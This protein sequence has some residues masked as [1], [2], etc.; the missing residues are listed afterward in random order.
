MRR[1]A[2]SWLLL[3]FLLLGSGVLG[4]V[5]NLAHALE[6]AIEDASHRDDGSPIQHEQHEHDETNCPVHAQLHMPAI[7][8]AWTPLLVL[9]GIWIPFLTQG[10]AVV[11]LRLHSPCFDSRGPPLLER[12]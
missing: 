7:S 4:Y 1:L 10:P 12:V 3:T 5:H 2:A 6:D 9:L 8:V 11:V